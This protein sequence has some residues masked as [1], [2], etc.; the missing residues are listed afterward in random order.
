MYFLRFKCKKK[1]CS[2]VV[3]DILYIFFPY[4][5]YASKLLFIILTKKVTN[6]NNCI[7]YDLFIILT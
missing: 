1:E 3:V 5:S 6:Y 2:N 4:Q 7:D